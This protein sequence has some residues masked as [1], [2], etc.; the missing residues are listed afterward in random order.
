VFLREFGD[1]IVTA[2]AA[3]PEPADPK[4]ED[5]HDDR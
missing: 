1:I 2:A 4:G 3:V 5:V